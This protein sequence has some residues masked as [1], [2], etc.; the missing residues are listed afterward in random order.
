[1]ALAGVTGT[2][3]VTVV[4]VAVSGIGVAAYHPEAARLARLAAGRSHQAMGW[5]SFGGNLGFATSPLLVGAVVATGGLEASPLLVVP[6]LVGAAL[7]VAAL[8]SMRIAAAD[9]PTQATPVV[10]TTVARSCCCPGPSSAGRS[11]SS[12]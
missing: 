7:C 12:P 10:A 6:A 4:V 9:S 8:R 5:F 2:Y 11:S 3:A 1:M